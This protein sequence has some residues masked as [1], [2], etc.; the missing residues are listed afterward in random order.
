MKRSVKD[1]NGYTVH[2]KDGNIGKVKDF[3][4]DDR[5]WTLRYIVVDTGNWLTGRKVLLSPIA[6]NRPDW[7]QMIFPVNLTKEEIEN[8]PGIEE[9]KPVSRQHEARLFQYF[10]WRPYWGSGLQA[11]AIPTPVPLPEEPEAEGKESNLRSSGEVI[12]YHIGATDGS[13][14]HVEDIIIDDS[15]WRIHYLVVDTRNLL[16]GKKVILATD[17][18]ENVNWTEK[19]IKVGLLKDAVKNSPEFNPA[20]DLDKDFEGEV[21]EHYGKEKS[22]G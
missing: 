10:G 14:G 9:H 20:F 16:P 13:I 22:W 6:V 12:G 15:S 4:F 19:I 18:I 3:Y 11:G 7:K 17:W 1:L 21:F 2:A 8:S 5:S